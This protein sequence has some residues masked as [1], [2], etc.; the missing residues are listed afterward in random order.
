MSR[1]FV[2]V[3]FQGQVIRTGSGFVI[4]STGTVLD[5]SSTIIDRLPSPPNLEDE[6]KEKRRRIDL[7]GQGKS[8]GRKR[9]PLLS[10]SINRPRPSLNH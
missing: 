8:G 4:R 7:L 6:E 10:L 5:R 3:R 2:F 1:S 9:F